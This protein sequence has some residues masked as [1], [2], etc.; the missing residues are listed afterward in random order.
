MVVEPNLAWW[1]RAVRIAVAV[2]IVAACMMGY[3]PAGV[4]WLALLLGGALLVNGL[5]GRCAIY[6][7]LGLSTCKIRKK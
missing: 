7:L 3:V 6:S 2:A 1:D 5:A 4:A